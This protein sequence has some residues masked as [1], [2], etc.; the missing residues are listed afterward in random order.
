MHE[1]PAQRWTVA[2]LAETLSISRSAFAERLKAVTGRPPLDYLTW[3]RLHRAAARLGRLDGSTIAMVAR[4][5]GYDSDPSFGK[6]F[7]REFGKSPGVVGRE[8]AAGSASPL[9]FELNK[10]T[11]FEVLEQESEL[12]LAR[13]ASQF[14]SE[15][16]ELF[17]RHGLI[18][19]EYNVLRILRGVGGG[20]GRESGDFVTTRSAHFRS[21]AIVCEARKNEVD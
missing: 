3:W 2:E 6:A 19:S 7:R 17:A 15:G 9:Q 14:Q 18:P 1:R 16:G 21:S 10:R 11:P 4:D 13:T 8:T 20:A 5:A 12:N